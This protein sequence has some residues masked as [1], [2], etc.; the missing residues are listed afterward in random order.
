MRIV[1]ASPGY[2]VND[3]LNIGQHN[4][5]SAAHLATGQLSMHKLFKTVALQ[6]NTEASKLPRS[7]QVLDVEHMQ[8]NDPLMPGRT[9]SGE[10]LLNRRVFNDGLLIMHRGEVIHESY[11]NG[12]SATDRHVIHSCS[13]SFCAM[14]VAIAIGEGKL[15][16]A[17]A[18]S[19]YV[20]ELQQRKEWQG[21]TLQ[22]VLDMCA[23]I[24]YSEDYTNPDAHYWQYARAAGY[25]P[26]LPGEAAIGARAWVIA[27]LN[28]RINNPGSTF[29][30]NSC[31]TIVIGMA[32]E[33]VYQRNLAQLFESMLYQRMGAESEAWFN[34]D[35]QGF[36]IVEG[37]LNLCLRDFARW[38]SLMINNGKNLG[39]EQI[40][41]E[42]F[43][44]QVVTVDPD[45]QRAF[46]AGE[47]DK[48]FPQGQYKNQFWVLNPGQQQFSM[49][50]IHGQFGWFDLQRELMLVGVGSFP[51]QD[52]E[53]MMRSLNTLWLGIASQL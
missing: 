14:L 1:T 12:M 23:G 50:G 27:N 10:Q 38:A 29:A 31:L 32:L 15:N 46:Q 43:V 6:P 21:V 48:L 42:D 51:Q 16:P 2:V 19:H 37:Q 22:H 45:A 7:M 41:P 20:E 24:E 39:G 44:E 30:Y 28:N 47:R 3:S 52:G 11:R 25:Y 33:N 36:P 5:D 8:F 53:L 40:L 17:Q 9:L 49:I 26:P 4:W 13:K 35:A 34:T 18:I